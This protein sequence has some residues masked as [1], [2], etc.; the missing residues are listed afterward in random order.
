[1][2]QSSRLVFNSSGAVLSVTGTAHQVAVGGTSTDAVL[3]LTSPI[4]VT[5][6]SFDSGTNKFFTYSSGTFSPSLIGS[7][8]NPTVTYATN[9]RIGYYMKHTLK[10]YVNAY[11]ETTTYSGGSGNAEL[12]NFPFTSGSV[13]ASISN[14]SISF[15]GITFLGSAKYYNITLAASSTT[16]NIGGI[17]SA[18]NATNL[19]LA[20]VSTASIFKY[21]N[22]YNL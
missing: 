9:G 11:V 14:G 10:C 15:S 5:G 18:G 19:T 22:I 13:S 12:G 21:S 1:M 16:A 3:S 20:N 7:T 2:S 17:Q 8:G 6:I 4:Y